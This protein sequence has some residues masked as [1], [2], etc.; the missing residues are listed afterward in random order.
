MQHAHIVDTIEL[1]VVPGIV[2]APLVDVEAYDP[3]RA[4]LR[5][6]QA[7]DTGA[8][9]AVQYALMIQIDG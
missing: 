6:C 1:R 2:D 9:A 8:T 4:Q 5:G 7:Q 3:L